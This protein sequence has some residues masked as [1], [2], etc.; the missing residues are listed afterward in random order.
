VGAVTDVA[1]PGDYFVTAVDEHRSYVVVRGGDGRLRAFANACPHRG[2]ELLEG[3]GCLDR[4]RCPY[5]AWTFDL[6]G[7]LV[8]VPGLKDMREVEVKQYGLREARVDVW[9]PFVFLNPDPNAGPLPEHLGTLPQVLDEYGVDLVGVAEQGNSLRYQGVLKCNWKIAVE[10]ALECYHCPTVHPGFKATVDLPNWHISLQGSCVVQGTRL[11]EDFAAQQTPGRMSDLVAASAYEQGGSDLAMFHWI[12][13]NNSVSLWPG[14]AN[15]F[16]FARW[17]PM[18]PDRCRWETI[19][20]WSAS[21]PDAVRDAQ[22]DFIAEVGEEDHVIVERVHR[23]MKSDAWTGGPF[24]LGRDLSED[25]DNTIRDER[26]PHR[27][28]SLVAQTVAS[29]WR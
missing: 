1:Q 25:T 22:W 10:N 28:N 3:S 26:G 24:M 8:G 2:S 20:W 15:S 18:G 17:V 4:I 13:P 7:A 6:N 21:V 23:G 16:N 27:F 9:G 11:R 29:F 5:H 19:R 12:F 14:P